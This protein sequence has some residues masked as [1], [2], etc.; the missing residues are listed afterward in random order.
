MF[1]WLRRVTT[2]ATE[3]GLWLSHTARGVPALLDYFLRRDR[4]RF[5]AV[6]DV[7]KKHVPGIERLEIG[8]PD[9]QRRSLE[10]V[11]EAGYRM[12][13]DEAS[14][15][16]RLLLFFIALAY[17]PTPPNI[18][19]LEEPETGIHPKRLA[20]VVRLL[21]EITRGEHG[22]QPAQVILTTHSPYLLDSV[23]L[24]ED[25]VLV[26]RRQDDGSR[27]AESADA[28]RLEAFLG[29]FLLG[30]LWYNEGEEGLIKR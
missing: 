17:H 2:I 23:K 25:T 11:L 12:P 3:L 13:A 18:I 24:L 10:L 7:V 1:P 19:L 5:F 14:S 15:G 6:T 9:P 4:D 27:T 8:T 29:E 26:F 16:V 22:G 28:T 20:D 21:R 30:E